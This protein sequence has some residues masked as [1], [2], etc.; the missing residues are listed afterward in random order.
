MQVANGFAYAEN[1][2]VDIHRAKLDA[3]EDLIESSLGESLL[4]A[5]WFKEDKLRIENLLRK[6]E[7]SFVSMDKSESIKAWKS[8]TVQSWAFASSLRG[9]WTQYTIRW[10]HSHLVLSS[11]E[12]RAL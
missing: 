11:M 8:K 10:L 12:L 2:T 9:A 7:V 5:Y 3:L 1:G 6:L 4:I